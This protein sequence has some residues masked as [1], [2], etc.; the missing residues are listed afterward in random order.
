M[1]GRTG[2]QDHM[3]PLLLVLFAGLVLCLAVLRAKGAALNGL[4]EYMLRRVHACLHERTFAT[5][6]GLHHE[7]QPVERKMREIAIWHLTVS[8]INAYEGEEASATTAGRE[9]SE[10]RTSQARPSRFFPPRPQRS[11]PCGGSWD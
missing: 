4:I 11:H 7:R 10:A 3:S 8:K 2:G 1:Q 5:V 9:K 6:T